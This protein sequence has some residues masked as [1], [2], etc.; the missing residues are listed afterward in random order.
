MR[1]RGSGSPDL[2]IVAV[3]RSG[4]KALG[5]RGSQWSETA[6]EERRGGETPRPRTTRRSGPGLA[7]VVRWPLSAGVASEGEA[8]DMTE[9]RDR[10]EANDAEMPQAGTLTRI[11]A[12]YAEAF[13]LRALI[14]GIPYVG[15]SLDTI[16][17]GRGSRWQYERLSAF[18]T[19]LDRRL[20]QV[21]V[22]GVVPD[23]DP[24]EPLF[25]FVMQVFDHVVR[26]RS[27]RK[28][29]AFAA[30]VARQV[31]QRHPWD[32]AEAAARLASELSDLDV[33]VLAA[34]ARAPLCEA[35]FNGLA[36]VTMSLQNVGG[37]VT[38]LQVLFPGVPDRALR[39]GCTTLVAR[40][41][42]HDEGAG[43]LSVGAMDYFV[44]T[45]VGKWFL[46]WLGEPQAN[47]D[48]A[49]G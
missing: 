28:R 18:L 2:V 12:Q 25:D 43:R 30:I 5:P 36:I 23:V 15:G 34:A 21:E 20:R 8:S 11:S 27:E 26:T 4:A 45:D 44:V 24:S 7:L 14:Q 9:P 16:L 47:A 46:E 37:G 17:A 3:N 10:V 22:H 31:V 6:A 49:V 33:A 1:G 32:D 38:L 40:G 13:P 48:G 19:L 39:L 42:L 41:L 35:P 29:E